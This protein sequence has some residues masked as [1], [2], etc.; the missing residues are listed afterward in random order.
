MPGRSLER[1]IE[2]LLSKHHLVSQGLAVLRQPAISPLLA[3][4]GIDGRN[5]RQWRTVKKKSVILTISHADVKNN[6]LTMTEHF[7]YF[8]PAVK[9]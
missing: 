9:L 8:S 1:A 3:L 2:L 5:V 7:T 4:L 6:Y